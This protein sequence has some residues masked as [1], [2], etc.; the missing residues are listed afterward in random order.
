[1]F[2]LLTNIRL[3]SRRDRKIFPG[4]AL[5]RQSNTSASRKRLKEQRAALEREE[6]A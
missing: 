6:E 5:H 2:P 3:N 4:A 1:V